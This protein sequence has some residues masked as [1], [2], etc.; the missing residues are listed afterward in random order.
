MIDVPEEKIE[1]LDPLLDAAV[2]LSPIRS[3]DDS[4]DDVEG[5]DA[6]DG[7]P[8]AINGKG[9]SKREKLALGVFGALAELRKL[10]L[11][12]TMPERG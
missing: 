12:E 6:V 7:G 3:G 4:R 9:N 11:L 5:Q 8:V 10:K 1:R 2:E